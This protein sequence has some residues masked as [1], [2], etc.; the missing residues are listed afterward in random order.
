MALTRYRDL[1]ARAGYGDRMGSSD[2]MP[3]PDERFRRVY[4]LTPA[5][6][7]IS[8]IALRRIKISRFDDL[9]DPFELLS[10][11][12]R[13]KRTRD[14]IQRYKTETN[15]TTGL[16]CFSGNWTNPVLW[17]HYGAKHTGICLG[18]DLI[19]PRALEV[20]Y[21]AERFVAELA[22]HANHENLDEN[23]KTSLLSTKFHH[24]AYE[25][26]YRV[27]V[28]LNTAVEHGG[29][30]FLAFSQEL[31]LAEVILGPH[32]RLPLSEVSRFVQQCCP[33]AR[34]YSARL[35]FKRFEVVP[36]KESVRRS[37]PSL[38]YE[39]HSLPASDASLSTSTFTSTTFGR[40]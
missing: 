26:E 16:I 12:F 33:D 1:W 4:Y 24:W 6:Y 15:N 36:Y 5:E 25:E 13:E 37:D 27:V 3:P 14:I 22:A 20:T 32:C 11:N 18:F 34:T 7:A 29:L 35:A 23:L 21:S 8:N 2:V 9:N 40:R 17:G 30:Y 10:P 31:A 38:G 19:R 39:E 28:P